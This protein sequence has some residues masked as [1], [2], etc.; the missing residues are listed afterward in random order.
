MR[1]HLTPPSVRGPWLVGLALA[2]VA[3][4][5]GNDEPVTLTTDTG[6]TDPTLIPVG[7]YDDILIAEG[8][9]TV[10]SILIGDFT[11]YPGFEA[12][13][14]EGQAQ[15]VRWLDGTTEV[16]V[17]VGNLDPNTTYSVHVHTQPCDDDAGPHYKLDPTI[18]ETE[19]ANELWPDVTTGADGIGTSL[20]S[21]GWVRGD[22]LSVV[23]HDPVTNDKMACADLEP[24]MEEGTVASGSFAPFAGAEK[25][26]SVIAGSAEIA[27]A[28]TSRITIDVYGLDPKT[29]Y[30][31]HLHALPCDTDDGGGHYKFDPSIEETLFDNEVWPDMTLS[32]DGR[33]ESTLFVEHRFREDAQ[34]VVV[35]RVAGKESPKVACAD[36]V[37]PDGAYLAAEKTGPPVL[38]ASGEGYGVDDMEGEATVIRRLD[39]VTEASIDIKKLEGQAV[40]PVHLHD[41]PCSAF[42]GGDHYLIDDTV[43]YVDEANE[44]WLNFSTRPRGGGDRTVA[45]PHLVRAEAQSFILHHADGARLACIDLQ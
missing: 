11:A 7:T 34:S 6:T 36:L 40:Y 12:T 31:A 41:A 10:H 44:L 8:P 17:G 20:L 16:S 35:H 29:T 5:G 9:A 39:G 18:E 21:T 14:V 42:S 23:V 45:I 27:I 22:A 4:G 26:D 43:D 28:E 32:P 30:T 3:C 37:R 33:A 38:L 25:I 13:G 15:L 24:T 1:A 2:F 19:A